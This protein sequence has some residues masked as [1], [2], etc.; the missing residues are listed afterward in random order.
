MAG[1]QRRQVDGLT[2]GGTLQ[3]RQGRGQVARQEIRQWRREGSSPQADLLD[4]PRHN[5]NRVL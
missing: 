1:R 5:S 4:E 2:R 3:E